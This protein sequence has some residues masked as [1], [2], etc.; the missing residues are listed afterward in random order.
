MRVKIDGTEY[1]LGES[2]R[3]P[4]TTLVE[5][6]ANLTADDLYDGNQAAPFLH[7]NGPKRIAIIKEIRTATGMNLKDAK[8]LSDR[9]PVAMP[10]M[11]ASRAQAFVNAVTMQGGHATMPNPPVVDRLAAIAERI[12]QET[13]VAEEL[14][15]KFMNAQVTLAKILQVGELNS[16]F[17]DKIEEHLS[18]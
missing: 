18:A 13:P 5:R 16:V 1:Q 2:W 3:A 15:T 10:V 12:E 4:L 14:F 17:R 7:A 8:A 6:L 11:T 9:V